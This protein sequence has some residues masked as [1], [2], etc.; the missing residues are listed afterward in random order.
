MSRSVFQLVR[1]LMVGFLVFAGL[2]SSAW[3]EVVPPDW[4]RSMAGEWEGAGERVQLVSRGRTQVEVRVDSR[5][6]GDLQPPALI[7]RNLFIETALGQ[8]GTPEGVR[9]YLRVYWVRE[10]ERSADIV[11]LEL[12]GGEDSA[13]PPA[14]T[15]FFNAETQRM[16]VRQALG[17]G[18]WVDSES[19][20]SD[21]ALT[22]YREFFFLGGQPRIQSSIDFHRVK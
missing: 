13:G 11:R 12:G 10:V 8:D 19:D 16:S 5:W 15:G 7:S 2:P 6:R 17:A 20:F 4:A 3:S 22:R 21:E 14:S 1:I 9:R 18:S